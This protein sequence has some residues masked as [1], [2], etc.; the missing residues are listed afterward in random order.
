[1]TCGEVN[2]GSLWTIFIVPV[3]M[4]AVTSVMVSFFTPTLTPSAQKPW[5]SFEEFFPFY[6]SQHQEVTCR[7][8]HIIGT[9]LVFLIA[10][11]QPASFQSLLLA[12][13]MGSIMF[14]LTRSL[15]HGLVEGAFMLGTYLYFM[16]LFTGNWK[17]GFLIPII[18]YGFAWV[19]HFAFEANKP[20]ALVY[21]FYSLLGDF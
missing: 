7:R 4:L 14:P 15:D 20:A 21:P 17:K 3:F 16:Y 13:L 19:G 18:A 9:S 11:F 6:M 10:L 2:K 5:G 8:L 1:M 12:G